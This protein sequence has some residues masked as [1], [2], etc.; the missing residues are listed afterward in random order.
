MS[1]NQIR[2]SKRF[3]EMALTLLMLVCMQLTVFAGTWKFDGPERWKWWYQND[4][5][6]YPHDTWEK[7]DGKWYHFA[8]SGYLNIGWLERNG[9]SYI[10]EEDGNTIGQMRENK[11]YRT[12][13][14]DG[15]GEVHRYHLKTWNGDWSNPI[16]YSVDEF[17]YEETGEKY[18]DIAKDLGLAVPASEVE[19]P[20]DFF[21]MNDSYVFDFDYFDTLQYYYPDRPDDRA[22]DLAFMKEEG[23]AVAKHYDVVT[24][25][26]KPN[27]DMY[28]YFHLI[29]EVI[30]SYGSNGDWNPVRYFVGGFGQN[31]AKAI[32][33]FDYNGE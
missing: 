17:Y 26:M 10:L 25:S 9:K 20:N 14:I 13:S 28:D 12:Y 33:W 8:G 21:R 15:N 11:K 4:D 16:E 6:S 2:I 1:R 31:R 23:I 3:L 30:D 24:F 7:I 5:G 29:T 22:V 32:Y 27:C 18:S 19:A